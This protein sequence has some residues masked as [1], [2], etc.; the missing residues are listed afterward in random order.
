MST[1]PIFLNIYSNKSSILIYLIDI[2]KLTG[3]QIKKFFIEIKN[4]K[5]FLVFLLI[6]KRDRCAHDIQH[7]NT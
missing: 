7:Q 4:R 2:V 3:G 1:N 5:E 6:L